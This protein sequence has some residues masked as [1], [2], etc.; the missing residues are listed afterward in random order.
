MKNH[1][2]LQSLLVAEIYPSAQP[3]YTNTNH[4]KNPG[5]MRDSNESEFMPLTHGLNASRLVI[6]T[7]LNNF[8]LGKKFH[9]REIFVY[10][11]RQRE[12]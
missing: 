1:G 7:S 10:L 11:R 12:I 4:K 2:Q 9:L 5:V 6:M 3:L 8:N